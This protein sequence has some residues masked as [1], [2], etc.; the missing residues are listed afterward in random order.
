MAGECILCGKCLEV[1][2]LLNATGREELGPRAKAD[3][4]SQLKKDEAG[5]SGEAVAGLAGRCLGCHRCA[6]VCSQGVDV[7]G[8]VA[9][10]RAAHPDF[11]SWLWKTWLVHARELWSSTSLAARLI[12]KKFQPEK[13]GQFLKML[14]GLKG[15]PGLEPFLSVESFP[16]TW[17]GEKM[18]LFAGCTANFVQARWLMTALRLLSGLGA[19][20]LPGEFECCGGGL[21]SA[22]FADEARAMAQGNIDVWRKAGRP[23]LVV[24]CA[25]CRSGLAGYADCFKDPAELRQW[26]DSITPLTALLRG[27]V[28]VLSEGAPGKVGYHRPCHVDN[29]DSDYIFLGNALGER[30]VAATQKECCGFGGL[31]R[32][33]APGLADQVNIKCWK[34]LGS[35][36]TV[37]SGCSACV[38]QLA[39]TGPDETQVGHWLEI[40]A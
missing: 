13:L 35:P 11:K 14:A 23:R 5:L 16:E 38:A 34:K 8:L 28:F 19:E 4:C 36:D 40:I 6:K 10:L 17:R 39:A 1:C 21:K 24:L 32:L 15:G 26:Q 20:V 37:L 7:P 31:M 33:G 9:A 30:L 29:A 22:G 18:L 2:P 3:L 25:S 27:A 12:P